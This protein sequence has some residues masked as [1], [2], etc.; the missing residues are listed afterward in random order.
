MKKVLTAMGNA[1]LNNELKRYLEYELNEND[2]FYQ[3]AVLDKLAEEKYDVLVV[4]AL[5]QGQFEFP[6]FI[7][8]I[9][10]IDKL[11]RIIIVTDEISS[12][13]RR[14]INE[15]KIVDVFLDSEVEIK[16]IID[17]INREEPI[18]KKCAAVKEEGTKYIATDNVELKSN[19][20]NE[21]IHFKGIT[22]KQE[23][24]VLSGIS[25]AGKST[26]A[27]NLS[28]V[29]ASKT[30]ARVLLIDLDT[31]N[32]NLDEI[33]E[34][35]RV[36]QN[37]KIAMDDNKRCGL[38]YAVELISKNR[39]D[40]NVFEELV[41]NIGNVDVLT[42]NTSLHY[43]QNV[44][45]E[46]HYNT[47]LECAKE[48]YDF[49]IIDT[50]SNIFLDSTKWALKRASRI[51]FTIENNYISVKKAT[52]FLN[53]M[54]DVWGVWKEKI[55]IVVNKESSKGIECEVIKKILGD[56]EIVGK[57]K[58]GEENI[59]LSY[60]KILQTINYIP[61]V[62]ILDRLFANRRVEVSE[63]NRIPMSKKE[64]ILNAN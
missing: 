39:F 32:G 41:I 28:K 36:P 44:L 10:A 56:Y 7:D 4:S 31:L 19:D 5:L 24:I 26:L 33:L 49:V 51:L 50:S 62:G 29:L 13:L 27:C 30:S 53:V 3:D 34:I 21:L 16:D 54:V 52:Q 40:A 60:S 22:Q 9:K 8:K 61:K 35:N 64:A 57:I 47:I 59:E 45:N 58:Y 15:E 38:N 25:G 20:I 18:R 2:L 17:S 46:N 55:E 63:S 12:D 1:T 6:D 42:G 11:V 43:C 37:I 14:K 23:I 48:K